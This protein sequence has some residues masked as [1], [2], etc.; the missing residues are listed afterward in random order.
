MTCLM[1]Y[2]AS[3]FVGGFEIE[4]YGGAVLAG[5]IISLLNYWVTTYLEERIFKDEA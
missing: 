5:I 3:Q 1:V 2:F 4:S